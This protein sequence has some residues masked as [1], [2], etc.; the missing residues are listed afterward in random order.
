[1]PSLKGKDVLDADWWGKGRGMR[2]LIVFCFPEW[3][4]SAKKWK[5]RKT[6]FHMIS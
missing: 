2:L 1:M 6:S 3:V 4:S 5:A